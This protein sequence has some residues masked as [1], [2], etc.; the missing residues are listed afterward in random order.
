[1]NL[2]G[3]GQFKPGNSGN[4]RGRPPKERALTSI[5]EAELNKTVTSADGVRVA[6]KRLIASLM[7]QIATEG[8]VTMPDGRELVVG[9]LKELTD[10]LKWIYRHVDGE[11]TQVD[12]TSL[13]ESFVQRVE[14]IAPDD[15][16]AT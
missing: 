5:L 10:I 13:G 11:K 6:R 1:M 14:V 3:K 2:T 9:D 16:A 4:P 12:I 8:R 15:P 7:A